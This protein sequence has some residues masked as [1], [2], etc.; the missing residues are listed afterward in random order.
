[1]QAE[2]G[3]TQSWNLLNLILT[4][5]WYLWQLCARNLAWKWQLCSGLLN[6]N[7]RSCDYVR[8]QTK[9]F[10][11]LEFCSRDVPMM[12]T[13]NY[14]YLSIHLPFDSNE[15]SSTIELSGITDYCGNQ[16]K[17]LTIWC[18]VN[19]YYIMWESN[20]TNSRRKHLMEY[21]VRKKKLY[22]E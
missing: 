12:R 1:M 8:N 19:A 21:L 17:Q 14:C 11:M 22:Y 20:G 16:K 2:E 3:K 6:D 5:A 10:P 13:L 9:T 7:P 15:S 4:T 18:Y